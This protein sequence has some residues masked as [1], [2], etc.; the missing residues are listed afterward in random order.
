MF[1]SDEALLENCSVQIERH[2]WSSVLHCDVDQ[3]YSSTGLYNFTLYQQRLVRFF[4][5]ATNFA[6]FQT[7]KQYFLRH[8]YGFTPMWQKQFFQRTV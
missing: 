1:T 7:Q 8:G 6:Q 4:D 3:M 5:F 2:N